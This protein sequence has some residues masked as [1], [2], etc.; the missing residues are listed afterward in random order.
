MREAQESTD[1]ETMLAAIRLNWQLWTIIQAELLSPECTTPIEL[2]NNALSL[3]KFIDKHTVEF[4]SQPE[5]KRLDILISLN[6]EIAGGLYETPK[7]E[8][9]EARPGPAEDSKGE[10]P[11]TP[12]SGHITCY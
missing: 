12:S 8:G 11:A 2:R 6:R 1:P 3:A 4:I 5:A 7:E 10:P 9:G